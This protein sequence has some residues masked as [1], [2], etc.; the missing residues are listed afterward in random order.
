MEE[1]FQIGVITAPHGVAGE[2]KVFP[3]TDEIS[4]IK[5]CH[6]GSR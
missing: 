2:V 1:R 4:E 6:I 5:R 3:T